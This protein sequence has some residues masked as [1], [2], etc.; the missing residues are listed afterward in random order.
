MKAD[1]KADRRDEIPSLMEPL[2]IEEGSR[3]ENWKRE[4]RDG[5]ADTEAGT[6]RPPAPGS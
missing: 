2:L 6:T 1:I 3:R 4:I 5:R